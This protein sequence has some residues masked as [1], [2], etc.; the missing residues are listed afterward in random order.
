LISR[1]TTSGDADSRRY[2]NASAVFNAPVRGVTVAGYGPAS[3]R[4]GKR[5]ARITERRQRPI[6]GAGGG[7][8]RV[9]GSWLEREDFAS[10]WVT[11]PISGADESVAPR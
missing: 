5:C 10:V 8:G 1:R 3:I 2:Y 11:E 9:D 7:V 6:N 4:T